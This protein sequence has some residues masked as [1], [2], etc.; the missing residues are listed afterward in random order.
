[1]QE[2][3]ITLENIITYVKLYWKLLADVLKSGESQ[4]VV[5]A[6]NQIIP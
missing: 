3:A 1:M 5:G 2:M 4:D 6:E